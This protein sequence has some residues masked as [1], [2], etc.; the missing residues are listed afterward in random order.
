MFDLGPVRPVIERMAET[1]W[2][3]FRKSITPIVSIRDGNTTHLGTGTYFRIG[4]ECFLVTAAHVWDAALRL[5]LDKSLHIFND[6]EASLA[7]VP[8][9]AELYHAKDPADVAVFALD[10]DSSPRLEGSYFLRLG[11]AALQP[12]TSGWCWVVGFPA[13]MAGERGAAF[14]FDQFSLLAPIDTRD[15]ALDRFNPRLHFLLDAAREYVAL[16]DGTAGNL[17]NRLEGIS[18]CSIWAVQWPRDNRAESWD[19]GTTRIVGVQTSYYRTSSVIKAT[20]WAAVV[21]V[22]VHSRPDLRGS[23]EMNFGPP[24]AEL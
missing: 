3:I 21:D 16:P 22:L 1:L 11:D 17:P 20:R 23:V 8:L 24:R 4:E 14:H 13:E 12:P 2:P 10:S 6:N 7:P 15:L 19:P 5:G 9:F 18:G